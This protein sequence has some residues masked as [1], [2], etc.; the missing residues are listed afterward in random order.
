MSNKQ[1]IPRIVLVLGLAGLIPF[2][3]SAVLLWIAGNGA[4]IGFVRILLVGYGAVI[5]S[6]LGGVR[7]GFEIARAPSSPSPWLL[8]ASVLPSI[9]GWIAVGIASAPINIIT[10]EQLI[11]VSFGILACGF[12]AQWHLDAQPVATSGLPPW[13]PLLRTILTM[14]VVV[15]LFL[16]NVA[17]TL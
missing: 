12:I 6:F 9:I 13:Y 2:F 17:L 10:T 16:G 7:W 1:P 14:G 8:V 15:A 4:L 5:L 11:V 3:A